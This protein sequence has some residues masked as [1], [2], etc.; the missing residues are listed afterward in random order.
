[1]DQGPVMGQSL[2]NVNLVGLDTGYCSLTGVFGVVALLKH[3][4]QGH[5]LLDIRQ[6][7]LF[8]YLDVFPWYV[9]SGPGTT[10]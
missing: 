9:M 5:F 4:F 2:H 8:K 1:M 3:P 6:H 7:D 10:V